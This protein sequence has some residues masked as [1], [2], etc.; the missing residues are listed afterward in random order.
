MRALRQAIGDSGREQRFIQTLHGH[1]YRFVATVAEQAEVM[2]E[3]T[4]C[5]AALTPVE[6][7]GALDA[8]TSL[9]EPVEPMLQETVSRTV[10]NAQAEPYVPCPHCHTEQAGH[11]QILR[12]VWDTP[13]PCMPRMWSHGRHPG[14]ILLCLWHRPLYPVTHGGPHGPRPIACA[15]GRARQPA[16]PAHASH[17]WRSG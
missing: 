14:A 3:E 7:D 17:A 1:G 11:C 9:C 10:T 6:V 13:G 16:C 5:G 2:A 4:S 12:A 15:R 8:P